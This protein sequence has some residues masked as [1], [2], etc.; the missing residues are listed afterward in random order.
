MKFF[1][2]TFVLL[3]LSVSLTGQ[4][5]TVTLPPD[6]AATCETWLCAGQ[7]NMQQGWG[8]YNATPEEKARV[9][10]EL[11]A[12]DKVDV[13]LWNFIDRTWIRLDRTNAL[14][15]CAVGVSFA[16]RRARATDRPIALLY[17]AAGGA[18][19]E[20]FLSKRTMDARK[21]DGTP[22][23]PHLAAMV[24]DGRSIDANAAFPCTWCA[25]EY[26]KRKG[27]GEEGAWWDISRLYEGGIRLLKNVPLTGI[28]W[29]QGESNAST[30][31]TPDVA[32]D[33]EYVEETLH[34]VVAELRGARKIPFLMFGLPV[35]N[36]PWETYRAAQRKV[37]EETG[38]VYLD[39]FGAGLGD[40]NDVHP[41]NKIPFAELA[42][43]AA[44]EATV[45]K[46]LWACG[47]GGIAGYR[48]VAICTATNGDLVAACDARDVNLCDLN[49]YHHIRIAVRRSS[50]G[51]RTWTPSRFA[52]DS[53]WV[54][55]GERW[56]ASDPSLVVD[57]VTGKIFLFSNAW[58]WTDPKDPS[59]HAYRF[60]V[61]ES[62][63]N[64]ATWTRPR[65]ITMDVAFSGW[66]FGKPS[67]IGRRDGEKACIF[68]PSGSGVQLAD[69]TL[70][71]TLC[72][73]NQGVALF[74]SSDHGWTW[75]AFG[76]PIAC[77]GDENKVVELKDG[78]LMINAR[79]RGGARAVYLS[80]D[81]GETWTPF[82]GE[83]LEDPT[84]NG[85]LKRLGDLLLFSNC[86]SSNRRCNVSLR[87]SADNGATWS[88][89]I[90][91]CPTESQYSDFTHLPNGDI[92]V[93]YEE[94]GGEG[95]Q[96]I[97]FKVIP[98]PE[99]ENQIGKS[100]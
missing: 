19:T 28:L 7:S 26:P 54:E 51:G 52:W 65:D 57:A 47:D 33:A 60:L 93:L 96:M 67:N 91:V 27:N 48:I 55:G 92:G 62:A 88:D 22:V 39:T 15:R 99:I 70:L 77:A 89:G 78:S 2:R 36:R 50:D 17:V 43:E 83:R 73:V 3:A 68:V 45:G 58:H 85:Q 18:P 90:T 29:Y 59:V 69:G 31:V 13:R 87:V 61:Q 95:R 11:V 23:Y 20:S 74:G 8:R 5:E 98:W 86:K 97:R 81:R 79:C 66:G 71:H 41:R 53:P 82:V 32:L 46:A 14:D 35:M 42:A 4:A 100:R 84:C 34:A 56:S 10:S 30:C 38:A 24:V 40:P 12:L 25:R 9:A 80:R 63:D 94:G 64:G 49:F 16:L 6:I 75:R 1:G 21:P 37:C 76:K 44:A 72:N